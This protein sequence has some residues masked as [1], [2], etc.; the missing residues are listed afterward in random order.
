[1]GRHV[2]QAR[3]DQR[4]L[5]E[6]GRKLYAYPSA[7]RVNLQRAHTF[8]TSISGHRL[9]PWLQNTGQPGFT[10]GM[11]SIRVHLPKPYPHTTK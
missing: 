1:M 8:A 9:H 2:E 10:D 6:A 4:R 3:G 7:H 5:E 11:A